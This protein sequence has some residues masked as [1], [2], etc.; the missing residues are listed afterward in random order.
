M[1]ETNDDFSPV[2]EYNNIFKEI[3]NMQSAVDVIES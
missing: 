2:D 3:N 1:F